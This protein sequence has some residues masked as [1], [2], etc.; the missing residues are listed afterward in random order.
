V[1]IEIVAGD[2]FWSI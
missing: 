2:I 1:A